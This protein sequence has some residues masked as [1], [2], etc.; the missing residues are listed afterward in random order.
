MMSQVDTVAAC[1]LWQVGI[2][3]TDTYVVQDPWPAGSH[4]GHR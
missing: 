2:Y 3:L 1:V 4:M